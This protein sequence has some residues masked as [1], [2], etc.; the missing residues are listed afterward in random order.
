[1]SNPVLTA[2]SERRSIRE[3]KPEQITKEQLDT[4]LQAAQQAPSAHNSQ[5]SRFTV[6][7]NRDILT[8]INEE[9][10]KTLDHPDIFYN[11]PTVIFV[12]VPVGGQFAAFTKVDSGI[13]VE[14]IAL[15]AYALGLGSVILGLPAL[16]LTG[17]RSDYFKSLLKIPPENEFA[18]A[19][20]VG[21]AAATKEAH[22]IE[23]D[24][25]QYI[26]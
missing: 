16:A 22:P 2:I 11:A 7:Q 14:N 10:R 19:I 3:Y 23:P 20:A 12:S 17:E 15:A 9:T 18:I 8:E 1:M 25:V 6:V 5:P 13:A 4:L 21:V 24:R 26:V